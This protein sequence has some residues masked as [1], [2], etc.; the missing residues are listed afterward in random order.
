MFNNVFSL[1]F[2]VELAVE[3]AHQGV[4]FNNGQ[5]CTAGSRIFVEEP[6]YDEFV[7]RS[8]ERARR[9]TVGNPFDPTIEQ[10]PQVRAS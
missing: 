9:R 3:Q 7:R 1:S 5:C 10:G 4:F 8:V 2:S 6:I